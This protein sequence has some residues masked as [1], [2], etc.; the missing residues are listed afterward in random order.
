MGDVRRLVVIA[1]LSAIAVVIYA[2]ESFI[3][4]PS[5]WLRFGFSHI[6]TLFSLVFFG[7]GTAFT[8][9]LIR[10]V[11]GSLLIGKLF[12]PTFVLG[13]CGGGAALASMALLLVVL[14][15]RGLSVVGISVA[16]AWVNNLVQ[17]LSAF[18]LFIRHGE[19]LMILP[20]F[21]LFA[22]AT[23]IVNG[24]A[25]FFLERYGREVL[26]LAARVTFPNV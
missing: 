24:I 19:I 13:L 15:G 1:L 23:G 11:V 22:V 17:V 4:T 9:F 26:G 16:G 7:T 14:K 10:T 12:S 6:I 3:P 20:A 18:A 8:I 5:P 21:L 2:V 25:V